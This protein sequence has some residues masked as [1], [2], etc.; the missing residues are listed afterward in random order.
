[1]YGATTKMGFG[2]KMVLNSPKG[3]M[4][5]WFIMLSFLSLK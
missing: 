4:L 5:E 2:A 3:A 1:M